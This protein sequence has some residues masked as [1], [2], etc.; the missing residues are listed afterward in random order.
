MQKSGEGEAGWG[1][2]L[3]GGMRE[4]EIRSTGV[5]GN[6]DQR[7]EGPAQLPTALLPLRNSTGS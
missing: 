3:K 2:Q 7:C 1:V 4:R 5:G 6:A